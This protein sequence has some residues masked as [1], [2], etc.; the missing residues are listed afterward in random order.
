MKDLAT[1]S[2]HSFNDGKNNIALLDIDTSSSYITSN[3]Y[4][5]SK[6]LKNNDMNSKCGSQKY[7]YNCQSDSNCV[8]RS[9]IDSTKSSSS[10]FMLCSKIFTGRQE[11][12]MITFNL[13]EQKVH[14]SNIHTHHRHILQF[15]TV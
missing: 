13:M 7:N 10:R 3:E 1:T 6:K 9:T 2:V 14:P 11:E 15:A 5:P 12:I 4:V 8:G